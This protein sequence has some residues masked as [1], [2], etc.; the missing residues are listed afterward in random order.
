MTSRP[1]KHGFWRVFAGLVAAVLG[2]QMLGR[3]VPVDATLWMATT[4]SGAAQIFVDKGAGYT[5]ADSVQTQLSDDGRLRAYSASFWAPPRKSKVRID[6]GVGSGTVRVCR[7]RFAS[8]YSS[9]ELDGPSLVNEIRVINALAAPVPDGSCIIMSATGADPHFEVKLKSRLFWWSWSKLLLGAFSLL[10]GLALLVRQLS[11]SA[12]ASSDW[13]PVSPGAWS[14]MGAAAAIFAVSIVGLGCA[15]V[16]C[17]P[18]GPTYGVQIFTALILSAAIG[19]AVT[20]LIAPSAPPRIFLAIVVGHAFLVVYVYGRSVLARSAPQLAIPAWEL[21]LLAGCALIY[22]GLLMRR[23]ARRAHHLVVRA[24][25]AL[26]VLA[27]V[28]VV[29]ADRELPRLLML[30]TDPDIHAFF[31][32]QIA[33][34]GFIPSSQGGWGSE[35]FN[36]PAGS[37]ALIY[38]WSRLS[39]LEV[40]NSVASLP[41]LLL[42]VT[43]LVVAEA[44]TPDD[45]SRPQQI[46]INASALLVTAAGLA[47]PLFLPFSHMEGYGRQLALPFFAAAAVLLIRIASRRQQSSSDYVVLFMLLVAVSALNPVNALLPV[48]VI[49]VVVLAVSARDRTVPWRALIPAVFMLPLLM[50]PYFQALFLGQEDAVQKLTLSPVL[51]DKSG[52]QV[53]SDAAAYF[54]RVG[55][56]FE[57]IALRL[58]PWDRYPSFIIALT[59]I[60]ALLLYLRGGWRPRLITVISGV[61]LIGLLAGMLAILAGVENDRKYYLLHPY[62]LVSIGQ[63][64]IVILMML[65]SV[66]VARLVSRY[67]LGPRAL[68]GCAIAMAVIA[69]PIR[70][71]Q[72]IES[73]PRVRE[74][75]LGSCLPADDLA[76]LRAMAEGELLRSSARNYDTEARILAPNVVAQMGLEKWAFPVGAARLLGQIETLPV[77]FYYMQGDPDFTA[78]AYEKHVCE[79]FDR[80]WLAKEKIEFLFVSARTDYACVKELDKQVADAEVVIRRGR[81]ML[82][83]VR[84]SI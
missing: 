55:I 19:L 31:A 75:Y 59:G 24:P 44:F 36:Y 84:P 65:G 15:D 20:S 32:N 58:L 48:V 11:R 40:A 7:I 27:A 38:A 80:A 18:R 16:A 81:A 1:S 62:F 68:A 64:K 9:S 78:D 57:E 3:Q 34:F 63:M 56:W 5:E 72:P 45:A 12:R 33:R 51:V 42:L 46:A 25:V 66:V 41:L 28:S 50:D 26:G 53:I 71:A 23:H 60:G 69:V 6:P 76:L 79:R 8:G 82:L 17:V 43:P 52:D 29:V 21:P 74:C 77:A 67:S 83:R 37:P 2:M 4:T 39:G 47:M 10:V 35:A 22:L 61:T 14:L 30:S 70:L 73:A 49:A 13:A 54:V